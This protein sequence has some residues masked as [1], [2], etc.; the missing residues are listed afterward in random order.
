MD[1]GFGVFVVEGSVPRVA[2][3][4]EGSAAGT[5]TAV[6]RYIQST[7]GLTAFLKMVWK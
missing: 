6:E 3:W 7:D 4:G 5:R 2:L 1:T